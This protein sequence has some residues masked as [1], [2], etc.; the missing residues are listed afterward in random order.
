[1][2]LSAARCRRSAETIRVR[3]V[4]EKNIKIVM[5]KFSRNFFSFAAFSI[6]S[7]FVFSCGKSSDL[8][9]IHREE[10][11]TL[12]YGNLED[13]INLFD[14]NSTGEI[15][16][17]I[18][19]RDGFFFIS[20]GKS[21][22]ILQMNSY[23]DLLTLYHNPETNPAPLFDE[24]VLADASNYSTRKTVSYPFHEPSF[25]AYALHRD[26]RP[27]MVVVTDVNEERLLRAEELFPVEEAKAD[28]IELHF[29]NTGKMEGLRMVVCQAEFELLRSIPT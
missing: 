27:S 14:L 24:N 10:K 23:G 5:E 1:M 9:S 21:Q 13:Q 3:A 25:L 11:F 7:L 8:S 17:R 26:V 22:K 16:T 4:Q 18:A 2:L 20:N 28:G 19:M 6:F 12:G 29:V 15:N